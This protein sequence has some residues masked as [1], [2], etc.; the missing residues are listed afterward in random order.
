MIMILP[1][2]ILLASNVSPIPAP[3]TVKIARISS[4]SKILCM[5]AFST[6]KIFPFNGR[7]AWKRRS[8]PC[9][10]LPPAESP[11]TTYSSQCS[12]SLMEQSASFPGNP[13][14]SNAFLRLVKSR[15]FLAASRASAARKHFS[16]MRLPSGEFSSSQ[17]ESAGPKIDSTILF[18][19]L[20]PSFVFVW[21][22]NCGSGTFVLITA[23]NPSRKSSPV[24]CTPPSFTM[25]FF[26]A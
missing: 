12:G 26:D 11:S 9:L 24:S 6:F 18:N 15:A 5:R 23:V 3:I 16:I 2:R 1:Y 10:A 8:R 25:P 20:L 21:P 22:S 14:P 19:S 13:P 7:I 17:S 4:F